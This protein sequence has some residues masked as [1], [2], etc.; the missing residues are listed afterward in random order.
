M[1]NGVTDFSKYMRHATRSEWWR[2]DVKG[3][4]NEQVF[5]ELKS[6]LVCPKCEGIAMTHGERGRAKC[7]SCHWEGRSV[8]LDEYIAEQSYRR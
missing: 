1:V 2:P 8:T 4:S 6:R 5:K 3:R 7:P